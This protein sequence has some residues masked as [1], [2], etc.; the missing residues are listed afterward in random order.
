MTYKTS[1]LNPHAKEF[2]PSK[3]ED[4]VA[5]HAELLAKRTLQRG[6]ERDFNKDEIGEIPKITS[7]DNLEQVAQIA[8][9]NLNCK[10]SYYELYWDGQ[11]A[12]LDSPSGSVQFP[13][14][15]IRQ[16][17]RYY[18]DDIPFEFAQDDTAL[19]DHASNAPAIAVNIIPIYEENSWHSWKQIA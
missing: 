11:H 15:T 17:V 12:I 1:T 16:I 6:S 2:I 8:Y 14:M 4:C 10:P 13:D 9:S 5:V 7:Y 19:D 3:T 18:F